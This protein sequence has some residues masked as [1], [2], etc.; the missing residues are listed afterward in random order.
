MGNGFLYFDSLRKRNRNPKRKAD[1]F[2]FLPEAL[3]RPLV[4]HPDLK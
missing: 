4:S 1:Y 2:F 3:I